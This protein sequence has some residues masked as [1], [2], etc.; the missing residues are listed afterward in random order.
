MG[1]LGLLGASIQGYECAGVS[2]VAA[3]L[4]TRAV[5][6]VDS[7]YRSGYSVQ[8]SLAMGGIEEFGS[9]ELKERLLPKMAKGQLLG[10][11]YS[12]NQPG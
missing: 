7:G 6:R 5:E 1:E 3:G 9:E 4:I 2:S 8:S 11:F 12:A 10:C